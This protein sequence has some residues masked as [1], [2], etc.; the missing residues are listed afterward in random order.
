M[1]YTGNFSTRFPSGPARSVPDPKAPKYAVVCAEIAVLP[2]AFGARE[3][4]LLF[5]T[6]NAVLLCWRIKID[7][8]ALATQR[9]DTSEIVC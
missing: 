8:A 6:L 7:T 4:V 3:L 5:S 1:D 9:S 2:L